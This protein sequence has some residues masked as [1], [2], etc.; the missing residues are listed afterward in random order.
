MKPAKK[1]VSPPA[2]PRLLPAL[3]NWTNESKSSEL[4]LAEVVIHDEDFSSAERLE[5]DGCTFKNITLTARLEK[6]RITDSIM[7]RMEAAGLYAGEGVWLRAEVR[8]SRFTGADL[9][10]SFFE[11]CLFKGV[12]FDGIGF[13]FA[14][15]KRVTFVECVLRKADFSSA[16]LTHV[17]FVDCN[18]E[19]TNFDAAVCKLVDLR[20][21]NLSNIKGVLGLKGATISNEQ[22]IQLAPLLAAELNFTIDD[23]A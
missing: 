7:T 9:G 5:A 19:E 22:L 3:T 14:K 4:E 10:A 16:Q 8:D 21:E 11:D 2:K 18:F 17:T 6:V 15:F 13:R 20:G 12:K 1:I 23:E